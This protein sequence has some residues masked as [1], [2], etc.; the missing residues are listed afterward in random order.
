MIRRPPRS[1]RPDT[2]FPYTTLFRSNCRQPFCRANAGR[3]FQTAPTRAGLP[4][5][6]ASAWSAPQKPCRSCLTRPPPPPQVDLPRPQS[7]RTLQSSNILSRSPYPSTRPL[8]PVGPRPPS[9]LPTSF[10]LS[11]P[12]GHGFLSKSKDP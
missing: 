7:Y 6:L 10:L 11:L 8:H 4:V 5:K 2:L 3:R 9:D 12:Y 1:T